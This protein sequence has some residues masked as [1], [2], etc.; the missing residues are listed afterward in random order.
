M[1]NVTIDKQKTKY[2]LEDIT[3]AYI[4]D[5]EG[6]M[7]Y[8]NK[9]I[10]A[11]GAFD[12][13]GGDL[14][15]KESYFFVYGGDVFDKGPNDIQVCTT[16]IK[17]KEQYPDR[18]VLI[19]GNRDANKLR[20]FSEAKFDE[21]EKEK[22]QQKSAPEKESGQTFQGEDPE[23]E[24]LKVHTE[25]NKLKWLLQHT[26]GSPGAFEFRREELQNKTGGPVL[27]NVVLQSYIDSVDPKI[28]SNSQS[29]IS[30]RAFVLKY[31]KL[32]QI[33]VQIN[34]ALFVHGGFIRETFNFV[35]NYKTFRYF[36]RLTGE[37][38]YENFDDIPLEPTANISN[39]EG[40]L[41]SM[42]VFRTHS[43]QTYLDNPCW[44]EDE[45]GNWVRG[46]EALAA[47][48][49][50]P[51]TLDL[52]AIYR[53]FL[54]EQGDVPKLSDCED[55]IQYLHD[56]EI[57]LVG[58]GHRPVGIAPLL[59]S[60]EDI[61]NVNEIPIRFCMA[62]TSYS[63]WGNKE[64]DNRGESYCSILFSFDGNRKFD[65][66]SLK[67]KIELNLGGET[68]KLETFDINIENLEATALGN[69]DKDILGGR[70]KVQDGDIE[71][72]YYVVAEVARNDDSGFEVRVAT[73]Q[74]GF[75]K[76]LK[77]Y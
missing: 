59:F 56:N 68:M 43:L 71:K 44:R 15:L 2:E 48:Q 33:G 67:G 57:Q 74:E 5:V 62:D 13:D 41:D 35:P 28:L 34:D 3:V 31:L 58:V 45:T 22:I 25:I 66:I 4:T 39:L 72:E 40:W 47:Y 6:N 53:S 61:K 54:N 8:F 38:V 16:L 63:G 30:Q 21:K 77:L 9:C 11:S 27:D 18:V 50:G 1:E 65:T 14:K 70:I 46:G 37:I 49:Y 12:R 55:L 20:I 64:K 51:A 52:S 73:K 42:E 19:I 17:L 60:I 69:P 7:E 24:L 75:K 32:G 10:D 23:E 76:L 29:E 26:L 36:D